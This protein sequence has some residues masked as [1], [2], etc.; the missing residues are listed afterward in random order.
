LN[1]DIIGS[2]NFVPAL[3]SVGFYQILR[4]QTVHVDDFLH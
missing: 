1:N 4:A 2:S 3:K